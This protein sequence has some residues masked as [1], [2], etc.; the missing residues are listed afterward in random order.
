MGLYYQ[1]GGFAPAPI[2][3]PCE[4][5]MVIYYEWY[6]AEDFIY[7]INNLF[8]TPQPYVSFNM[9]DGSYYLF[10]VTS[11]TLTFNDIVTWCNTN[12]PGMN[13]FY[14]EFDTGYLRFTL[15][16]EL[17]C[18]EQPYYFSIC[19]SDV[20]GSCQ[21]DEFINKTS[22][23]N[24]CVCGDKC[25]LPAG[26]ETSTSGLYVSYTQG[27]DPINTIRANNGRYLTISLYDGVNRIQ[28]HQ[29]LI[30][31]DVS[32]SDAQCYLEINSWAATIQGMTVTDLGLG[33]DVSFA[34]TTEAPCGVSYQ[35]DMSILA[36]DGT[37]I[38][39][40]GQSFPTFCPCPPPPSEDTLYALYSLSNIINIDN[41]DCF[42]TMIEFWG[43]NETMVSGFEYFNDWKQRIRLG[44]NGGGDKPVIE[45]SLYRQS[46]GV[47]RRPQS[48][49]DLSLDLHTD[50]L[51]LPTQLALVDA[52]RH[53]YF[54]WN[55]QNVFVK[56][57]IEVAT[58]QDFT[59][60]SS[61][62]TLAQVKFQVLKQ[63]FQP[64]NS[65]CL[66]C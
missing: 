46:N 32:D 50:F 39:N 41:S 33:N 40:I 44:I 10:T 30:D 22:V 51:D 3:P 66:T 11:N 58:I 23:E 31:F 24:Y 4:L 37:V 48:K 64:K 49:Q 7:G 42:S 60:Q 5:E 17:P 35:M 9:P 28:K 16:M 21:E 34:W 14:D 18:Q 1:P 57:D 59:T 61:F 8:S 56:G 38:G 52:T 25:V 55:G 27:F 47:H 36:I 12:I 26:T 62:E 6:E 45:E 2:D 43:N 13:A 53:P 63:G 29:F 65:S 15:T 19:A 20:D 54:V